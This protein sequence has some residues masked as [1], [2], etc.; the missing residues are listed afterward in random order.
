M[1][2]V[3]RLGG[4]EFI[5]LMPNSSIGKAMIRARK[6]GNALNDLSF[7]WKGETIRLQASIGLK[8]YVR[9]DTIENIIDQ[10]DQGLYKDKKFRKENSSFAAE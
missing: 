6:L 3:A 2:V 9:G 7:D 10:A 5:I 8:E 4:D 1:D